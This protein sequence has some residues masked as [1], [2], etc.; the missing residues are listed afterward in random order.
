M[1]ILFGVFDWGQGHATRDLPLISELVKKNEVDIISTGRALA[2]LKNRFGKKCRYFDVPSV[3]PPYPKSS[4]FVLKFSVSI[5]RMLSDL[6][7]ARKISEK[8]IASGYDIIISDCRYDVYDKKENSFLI[9]HQL[10]FKSP[11]FE[12]VAENFLASVMSKYG[13]VIVPDFPGREL[14]GELSMNPR[15]NGIVE[16][17]GI[18]SQLKKR[19]LK[20][21][22]DYF[23]SISG[24]EPQ[25]TIF[26]EKILGQIENLSG[27]IV[28]AGG[29][30][31]A[32]K[33]QERK[34]IKFFS[35]L[36]SKKQE[37]M[38]NRAKFIVTRSGYT[39]ILEL[40]EL[41]K[42]NVLLVPTPGMTEQEYIA[43]LYE[44][45]KF[46]HHVHQ[47]KLNLEKDIQ[48]ARGFSGFKPRWKTKESIK[49]ILKIIF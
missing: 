14:T 1:K 37:E 5:P 10:K 42:K 41:E 18:L 44:K 24:P 17:P 6:K 11:A 36:D 3:Y 4:L 31:D 16:Y 21:D 25:R 20:K 23:F 26:E 48:D 38:M 9:N 15:F 12:F 29:N 8:I 13:A 39:T 28:V 22:I 47:D 33:K 7:K 49:K 43:D 27:K 35:F 19:N 32:T 45:K 46:W 30:P 2:I 40:S 34:N